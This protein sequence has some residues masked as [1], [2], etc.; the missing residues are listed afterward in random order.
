[1]G[2]HIADY[3]VDYPLSPLETV[4]GK[5]RMMEDHFTNADGNDVTPSFTELS[6]PAGRRGQA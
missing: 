4:A 5:T 1:M 6:A 3:A 2:G